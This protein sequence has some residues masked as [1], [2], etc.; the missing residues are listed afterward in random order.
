MDFISRGYEKGG[1]KNG[2]GNTSH[3][4]EKETSLKKDRTYWKTKINDGTIHPYSKDDNES[5]KR[6]RIN[7]DG[8]FMTLQKGPI[9]SMYT[10][11]WF[12]RSG[13]EENCW[14]N[15]CN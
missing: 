8:L 2:S 12:L 10:L 15:G 13:K 6:E 7:E 9:T 11:D 1:E 3:E 14:E 5:R 4:K